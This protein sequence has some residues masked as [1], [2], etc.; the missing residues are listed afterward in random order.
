MSSWIKVNE[1]RII[2]LGEE[3]LRALMHRLLPVSA[4]DAGCDVSK[5]TVNPR[6][7]ARD[8]GCDAYTPHSGKKHTWL[9]AEETCWQLKA[10]DAG[11]PSRVANEVTKPIPQEI[12]RKGGWL[13][14][15]AAACS[16]G[17]AGIADR[18]NALIDAA[19][20]LGLP[21][22]KILVYSADILATWASE[23]PPAAAFLYDV[24]DGGILTLEEWESEER[25]QLP[26]TPAG[27][28][29]DELLVLRDQFLDR[30][31]DP[32]EPR[33]AYV[34]GQAGVG[35]SR[36]AMEAA[37]D[38]KSRGSTVYLRSSKSDQIN[39]I[40]S[41]LQRNPKANLI[42]IAD[43]AASDEQVWVNARMQVDRFKGR[44]RVLLIAPRLDREAPQDTLQ[45][46][47]ETDDKQ[48]EQIVSG[49]FPNMPSEHKTFVVNQS[50]RNIRMAR[51]VGE[52]MDKG[53]ITSASGLFT[54]P[55]IQGLL[56]RIL[57][58]ADRD[59]LSVVAAGESVG[60][61][62]E[63]EQEGRMI[64]EKLGLK[65]EN[66]QRKVFE[67]DTRLGIAP[68][69]GSRR[70][71]SP[72]PLGRYL[73]HGLWVANTSAM[74][75]LT[76]ELPDR[77]RAQL[78][79]RLQDLGNDP[80]TEK[81]AREEVEQFKLLEDFREQARARLF[82]SVAKVLPDAALARLKDVLKKTSH[83][84]IKAFGGDGRRELIWELDQLSWQSKNFEDA[85]WSLAFLAAGENEGI[86]NNATG[87]LESRFQVILGGT[88]LP[89][90]E[91]LSVLDGLWNL[92]R[93]ELTPIILS[94]LKEAA[95]DHVT[96]FDSGYSR[97]HVLEPEWQPK[98]NADAFQCIQ[99]A[100]QAV[101]R[102]IR[103]E[104]I[105]KHETACMAL[106]SAYVPLLD[107]PKLFESV[108][109]ILQRVIDTFPAKREEIRL[110]L[111]RHIRWHEDVAKRNRHKLPDTLNSQR[112]LHESLRNKTFEGRVIEFVG[113]PSWE[114]DVTRENEMERLAKEVF[115]NPRLLDGDGGKWLTAGEAGDPWTFGKA[116]AKQD[117]S[118][119][120]LLKIWKLTLSGTDDRLLGG[121]LAILEERGRKDFVDDWLD[122]RSKGEE[123]HDFIFGLTTKLALSEKSQA[124]ILRMLKEEKASERSI[125]WLK[126][127]GVMDKVPLDT[128][129]TVL[130][131]L[132]AKKEWRPVALD[133]FAGRLGRAKDVNTENK[134]LLKVAADL[135]SDT[136]LIYER[137]MSEYDWTQVAEWY[138]E[139]DPVK[140][141]ETLLDAHLGKANNGSGTWFLQHSQASKTFL[142]A[143]KTKPDEVWKMLAKRLE[144]E[145]AF[146]FTI[147]FPEG[148]I[149][150]VPNGLI[151]KWA[152]EDPEKRVR[153]LT[154]IVSI[155]PEKE[156]S[157]GMKLLAKFGKIDDLDDDFSAAYV[158]GSWSGK[159]SD[160]FSRLAKRLEDAL[161]GSKDA[162]VQ[163]WLKETASNLRADAVREREREEEERV[164]RGF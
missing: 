118:D 159:T 92:E 147:G 59:A 141:A 53:S 21:T 40:A 14:V 6:T 63:A 160:Y 12:L 84:E 23:Y 98:T 94:V 154:R 37:R 145:D 152:A 150:I 82:R 91:R 123:G 116:L 129:V 153:Y 70:Y 26:F 132:T 32:G 16:N 107:V 74:R 42:V 161:P 138:L 80:T 66:V 55:E 77:G 87:V 65:W 105:S 49:W 85:V 104:R 106:A 56:D 18:E 17:A 124:R 57:G 2:E 79:A 73:A 34:V 62:G 78:L 99:G 72:A 31:F 163:Q 151:L 41:Y 157:L 47:R 121:Y 88:A 156:D 38:S 137:H 108:A 113:Q 86:S 136:A 48:L 110:V 103:D 58:G 9:K 144:G 51:L 130:E 10:G 164:L 126:Y 39:T 101:E 24:A 135:V 119:G 4:H 148:L 122:E 162:T 50:E 114:A 139:H 30:S 43:E 44:L 81:V 52:A 90:L 117:E 64:A 134:R 15:I 143:L 128:F 93:P 149:D 111:R 19:K 69:A 28:M 142:H 102:Y 11:L 7:K 97:T 68:Q 27:V 20:K 67:A 115:S 100:V 109:G 46:K 29:K 45:F 158:S 133:V 71:I 127:G 95:N 5:V 131:L 125:Y 54:H 89:Y 36:F 155:E 146:R 140:V 76:R 96:R 120:L 112:E 3:E 8:R 61:S 35:K 22:D 1:E 25:H 33:I 13:I 75:E 83:E 60:W